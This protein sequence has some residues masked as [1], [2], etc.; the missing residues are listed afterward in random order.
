M[1]FLPKDL[2][3][4]RKFAPFRFLPT[5]ANSSN[6]NLAEVRFQRVEYMYANAKWKRENMCLYLKIFSLDINISIYL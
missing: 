3:W 1:V 2:R 5:H 6:S 4:G